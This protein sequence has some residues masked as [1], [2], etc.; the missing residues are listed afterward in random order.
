MTSSK[1]GRRRSDSSDVVEGGNSDDQLLDALSTSLDSCKQRKAIL[2]ELN[3]KPAERFLDIGCGL[4]HLCAQARSLV[5]AQGSVF[6]ID[7]CPE[8]IQFAQ[9]RWGDGCSFRIADATTLQ[10]AKQTFDAVAC[11]QVA[12]YLNDITRFL[13]TVRRL[14]KPRGRLLIV[15]TD[16]DSLVW[17]SANPE[18]MSAVQ[19]AWSGH[20]AEPRLPTKLDHYLEAANF[21]VRSHT[22]HTI[23]NRTF[24]SPRFS[25]GLARSILEYMNVVRQDADAIDLTAWFEE[26]SKSSRE[27]RYFF[28]IQR[29]LF[30]A[31]RND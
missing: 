24:R 8:S 29:S 1:T 16:W 3:L 30:L 17:R 9:R 7:L 21:R 6:G 15:S 26:L 12:E 13:K 28:E 4:G 22:H 23:A 10:F 19:R 11:V 27:R 18:R 25:Y 31:I 5:G 20:C 2:G 14:L